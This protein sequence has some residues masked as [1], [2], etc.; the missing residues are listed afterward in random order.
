MISNNCPQPTR[1]PAA[2]DV[3]AVPSVPDEA[4]ALV[5]VLTWNVQHASAA[6]TYR[7][8]LWLATGHGAD[9]LVLTEVA[10]G[11]SG[12]L[13]AGYLEEIGYTVVLPAPDQDDRYRVL[14]ACRIGVLDRVDVGISVLP[15]RGISARITWPEAQVGVVGLYV[16]SRGPQHR[17]NVA[18]RAFQDAVTSA[19]PGL[20]DRL[21]ITGP[22]VI[23]G[24][25]NVVEPGHDPHYPVFGTWEYDF[26]RS[27][28]DNGFTDA[29]RLRYP[30]GMDYSW[31]GRPSGE[32]ARNGYRFDHAFVTAAHFGVVRDCR[33]LHTVRENGLSDHSAMA[34]TLAL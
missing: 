27:F 17:R 28:A 3:N 30:S 15:H 4:T 29:F 22:I 8:A 9:V 33:Y 31:F 7:Q 23:A 18:K 34:L 14:L 2:A 12:Q 32:G 16:P 11:H 19:L 26:Y 25:L 10:A 1:V 20:A 5:R 13:L 24:D 6:R 21:G